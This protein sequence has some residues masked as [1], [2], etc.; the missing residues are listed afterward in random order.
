MERAN[1][2][3]T[4]TTKDHEDAWFCC[5]MNVS[6]CGLSSKQYYE[7]P[8]IDGYFI[9]LTRAACGPLI[10]QLWSHDMSISDPNALISSFSCNHVTCKPY[11]KFCNVYGIGIFA[12]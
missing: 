11:S 5:T 12:R 8:L 10:T 3:G 1:P 2:G 7:P 6:L 4:H 9:S